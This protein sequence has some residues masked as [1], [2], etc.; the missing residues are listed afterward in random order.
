MTCACVAKLIAQVIAHIDRRVFIVSESPSTLYP[1]K[2]AAIIY[3]GE[4]PYKLLRVTENVLFVNKR[5]INV[6]RTS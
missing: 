4:C 5:F 3:V 2:L 6:A 1:F